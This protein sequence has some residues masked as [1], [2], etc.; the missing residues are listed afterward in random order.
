M[1]IVIA[2]VVFCAEIWSIDCS[3]TKRLFFCIL[4]VCYFIYFGT[5]LI[6]YYIIDTNGVTVVLYGFIKRTVSWENLSCVEA[7]ILVGPRICRPYIVCTKH[8][9]PFKIKSPV[10]KLLR[11]FTVCV[12]EYSPE[13]VCALEQCGVSLKYSTPYGEVMNSY[14]R[15]HSQSW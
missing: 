4:Y 8:G 12:F 13:R 15:I 11:P 10:L 5:Y 3:L 9:W 7:L 6:H 2:C 14:K 1:V